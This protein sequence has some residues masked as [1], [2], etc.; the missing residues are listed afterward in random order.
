MLEAIFPGVGED[1]I[2]R[3]HAAAERRAGVALGV[4]WAAKRMPG[5]RAIK[6]RRRAKRLGTRN[7][8]IPE[9]ARGL[10][11]SKR[12]V[13]TFRAGEQGQWRPIG[14]KRAGRRACVRPSAARCM[15]YARP[16]STW[17]SGGGR[18][19]RSKSAQSRHRSVGL[20][21]D[22]RAYAVS[23]SCFT[24]GVCMGMAMSVSSMR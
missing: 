15:K 6:T 4:L 10:V 16:S 3:F 7:K 13:S 24:S 9:R 8:R 18:I 17:K 20:H 21:Q 5:A 12:S 2:Q 23:S 14:C 1:G 19:L 11:S 22:E